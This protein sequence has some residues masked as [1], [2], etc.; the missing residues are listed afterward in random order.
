MHFPRSRDR[1]TTETRRALTRTPHGL[2]RQRR[3]T[4]QNS[5]DAATL[6]RRRASRRS[7][8]RFDDQTACVLLSARD[9]GDNRA[10]PPCAAGSLC[11]P[12]GLSPRSAEGYGAAAHH[13]S[14]NNCKTPMTFAS[15]RRPIT[16]RF[17]TRGESKPSRNRG[18]CTL[19]VGTPI[20]PAKFRGPQGGLPCTRTTVVRS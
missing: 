12:R 20:R 2:F 13:A 14:I 3:A 9:L 7:I 10:R 4:T 5:G 11:E 18:F 15:R 19:L 6:M 8:A 17:R 1:N 16:L